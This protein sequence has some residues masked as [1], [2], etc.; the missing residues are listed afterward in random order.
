MCRHED[1]KLIS[2]SRLGK[3]IG[4]VFDD[5]ITMAEASTLAR[6]DPDLFKPEFVAV[7]AGDSWEL[8]STRRDVGSVG[9]SLLHEWTLAHAADDPIAVYPPPRRSSVPRPRS[10]SLE[11]MVICTGER[12][13]QRSA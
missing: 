8:A 12:A 6:N 5:A 2:S 13:R 1:L 4:F 10:S 3:L 9:A 11:T 7:S